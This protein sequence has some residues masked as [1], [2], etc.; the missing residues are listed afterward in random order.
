MR[1][2]RSGCRQIGWNWMDGGDGA[3][4]GDDMEWML[5]GRIAP[6]RFANGCGWARRVGA[7]TGALNRRWRWALRAAC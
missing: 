7:V 2:G 5:D 1:G 3:D 4:G 6:R